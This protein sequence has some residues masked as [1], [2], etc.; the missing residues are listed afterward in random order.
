MVSKM[1][2]QSPEYYMLYEILR[3]LQRMTQVASKISTGGGGLPPSPT[4]QAT[5]IVATN[6]TDT[7]LTV[8][9]TRGN[10]ASILVVA[11][12]GSAVNAVPS[13]S[14]DYTASSVY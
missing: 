2:G 12:Q 13:E 10:G 3:K 11:R 8:S 1:I 7:S 6:I 5:S 9:W 4:T 14:V